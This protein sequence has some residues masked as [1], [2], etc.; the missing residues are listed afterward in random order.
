V[1]NEGLAF[2]L[3]VAA[4]AVL[5]VWG[6]QRAETLA[7]RLLLAVAAPAAAA[8]LWGLFAAQAYPEKIGTPH[9]MPGLD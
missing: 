5:A 6:W 3:E 2:L 4:L 8:V 1:I 7:V 9:Q